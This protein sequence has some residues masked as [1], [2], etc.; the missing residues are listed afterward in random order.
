MK[1]TSRLITF[2]VALVIVLA[3]AGPAFA[4][5]T[6]NEQY[7][8]SS[9]VMYNNYT[10]KSSNTNSI[11]HLSINLNDA[12]TNVTLGM[13]D[14]FTSRIRTTALATKNSTEGNRV[15]GAVNAAFF[16][17]GEGYPLFL[18][19]QNNR[20]I[21]GGIVSNG[22]SEYMNVPTAFGMKENGEAVIDYFDFDVN[23]T[24]NGETLQ[25]NGMNRERNNQETI[26]F[27]PEFYKPGTN[28]NQYGYEIVVDAGTSTRNIHFG[29]TISGK[30]VQVLPYGQS[31]SKIP[32]NGFVIS[33]QGASPLNAKLQKLTPGTDVS[34]NFSIDS[35]WNNAQF[36]VASGPMLVRNGQPYIMMSTS[37]PRAKEVTART[38]VGISKD[39]KTVHFV[40]VDGKQSKSPG[41]NMSQLADYLIRLGVDTAINLDG[42]GSTT[43]G[44]RK[45]GSNNVV[46]ANVP[47]AGSERAVNAILQAVSTAP[48]SEAAT[49]KYTRNNVGTMLVGTTSTINVQYVLDQY[50]N[51][52]P[53]ANGTMSFSSQNGTLQVSGYSFTTTKAGDDRL[54]MAHNGKVIQSFPVKVVDGPSTLTISGTKTLG[55]KQ[56][57][58]Y[59]ISALDD[60]GKP[61]IYNAD[62]VKWSVEGGIGSISSSGQFTATKE[63][64]GSI[65]AKLGSKTASFPVTVKGAALFTDIPADYIYAKEVKFL[66]D[67]KYVTGYG[68][69]TFKPNQTLSRA[70]AAVIISRV[71]GLDTTKVKDPGFKDVTPS[72]QYYKEIAAVQNAGIISGVNGAYNPNSY[73]TRAQMAKIVANAFKLKGVSN[74]QF[75]DVPKTSWEYEFVQALAANNITTGY[76]NNLFKPY[77]SI[78]RMHFGLFLYRVLN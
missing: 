19:A 68:D 21:N 64:Q 9:G 46:L 43:M 4:F 78:T 77:E 71:L 36:I 5:Q 53:I 24:A 29:D 41:M 66:V 2:M 51:P 56:S 58:A 40:T 16:N 31:V 74:I 47:A 50:Y 3:Q 65:V 38:V 10:Y 73:L 14:P 63:G 52:L 37:S 54:Y 18:I 70:H 59:S 15:V 42:G 33:V 49:I 62:Q 72:H 22:S 45:Y 25:L 6:I 7:P 23:L 20:I 28:S 30:V 69:G 44:I 55:V 12:Y 32:E 26:L 35:Q 34:V 17:M 11:N 57:A 8:L 75:T 76:G 1:K 13:P 48:T 39:K 60:A 67:K 27:T 61:I